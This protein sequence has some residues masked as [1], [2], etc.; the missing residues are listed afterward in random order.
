M[1]SLFCSFAPWRQDIAEHC[2]VLAANLAPIK[3]AAAT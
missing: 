3:K 1:T 2:G